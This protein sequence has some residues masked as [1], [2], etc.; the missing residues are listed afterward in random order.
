MEVGDELHF[1]EILASAASHAAKAC[2]SGLIGGALQVILFMWMETT[3][4]Y[5]CCNGGGFRNALK[6]LWK[7]GGIPRFYN[8]VTM[9]IVQV[10]LLRCGDVTSNELII[11]LLNVYWIALPTPLKTCVAASVACLWRF[12][13]GPIDTIKVTYQVSGRDAGYQLWQ[14]IRKEGIC[15]LWAGSTMACFGAWIGFCAFFSVFNFINAVWTEPEDPESRL[16]RLSVM[17]L[18]SSTFATICGNLMRVLKILR[19]SSASCQLSYYQTAKK[20]IDEEGWAAFVTRGLGTRV[21]SIVLQGTMFTI[22]WKSIEE[23]LSSH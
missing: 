1:K 23:S 11:R 9:A 20:V 3:S 19:Q 4:A 8:G 10:P 16:L 15:I 5:Q 21:V 17:G 22:L 7:E 12:A 13:L 18:C 6:A 14:R 2:L